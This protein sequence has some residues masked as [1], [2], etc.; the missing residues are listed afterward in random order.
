MTT[1]AP[2]AVRQQLQRI[3]DSSALAN[4]DQLKRLL[5]YTTERA[6]AGEGNQVKEYLLGVEVFG[7]P[8]TYDPRLDPIVRVQAR[9]LRAKLDDYYLTEGRGDPIVFRMPKGGYAPSFHLPAAA[10]PSPRRRW[11]WASVAVV[12]LLAAGWAIWSVPPAAAESTVVAVLP[13]V[14]VSRE[15]PVEILADKL[16][17]GLITEL[18]R[19]P[20]IRVK[21]RTTMMQYKGV[22]RP[23]PEIAREL[24]AGVVFEGGVF[25]EEGRMAF[26]ARL[27]DPVSDTKIWA[28][29]YDRPEGE[30]LTFQREVA[31]A[32]ADA[33][34]RYVARERG[35]R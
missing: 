12:P 10:P 11:I 18:A 9:R 28:D 32:L 21:S 30:I 23:L 33:L 7:R 35:S 22:K 15:P 34:R 3:L 5:R 27:V 24:N 17:E 8:D 6:L 25:L 19:L 14:N 20:G 4:S 16:T 13:V 26:K 31:A 29:V 1:P 2:A